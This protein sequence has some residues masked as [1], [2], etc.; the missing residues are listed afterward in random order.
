MRLPEAGSVSAFLF[1]RR[2]VVVDEIALSFA[3]ARVWRSTTS[4]DGI[5]GYH[6]DSNFDLEDE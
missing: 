5:Q 6:I 3:D 2:I 4:A 1:T